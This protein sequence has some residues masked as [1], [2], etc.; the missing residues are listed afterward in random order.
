[1]SRLFLTFLLLLP[2]AAWAVA[3]T[4]TAVEGILHSA[5]GG[6]VADGE[7]TL[8]FALYP[9]S[10]N[11]AALWSEGPVAV[12]VKNG[13][14]YW[15]L[16]S[17]EPLKADVLALAPTI[18]LGIKV[19]ADPEMPRK[20]LLSV[21]FALQAATATNLACSGCVTVANL[22][23]A[24]LTPYAKTATLS[25]VA[26]SGEYGDLLNLP[27]LSAYAKNN[28]LADVAK[29]GKYADLQNAPDISLYAKTADLSVY[30]KLNLLAK[31]AS[32]GLYADL[33]DPPKLAPVATSG[34]YTDLLNAPKL[35]KV[36]TSGLFSDLSG[37]GLTLNVGLHPQVDPVG[38]Y[39][40][41]NT[42]TG[43]MEVFD[44]QKWWYFLSN[45]ASSDPNT[46][47]LLHFDGADGAKNST[48]ASS[49]K[50]V[51]TF[52]NNA[53]ISIGNSKFGGSSAYFDGA[54]HISIACASAFQ[55]AHGDMTVE[56]WFN[57]N[58]VNTSYQ[59]LYASGGDFHSPNIEYYEG[60]CGGNTTTF[61]WSTNNASWANGGLGTCG[62]SGLYQ[63][64]TWYHLALVRYAG[65]FYKYINGKLDGMSDATTSLQ[66][67]CDAP[68]TLGWWNKPGRY[69]SGYMD[70]VRV[71]RVAR[72]TNNFV[73]QAGAF[74]Q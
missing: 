30:A 62:A 6:A 57:L 63:S 74:L 40:L 70:E 31:V 7:Y 55:F 50:N 20:Q 71:S 72:Y 34:L 23:P 67:A 39:F 37:A 41:Y 4:V 5:G 27:D 38:T 54:S 1:M 35:A 46:V 66:A 3:P 58:D 52:A 10:S 36:A 11:G 9:S 16:G 26:T 22:D 19:G 13:G 32:S 53:K 56:F 12:N 24:I 68:I 33:L 60:G 17:T 48:D 73:P 29:T 18:W 21:P 51:L 28:T 25:K 2:A 15:A 69:L 61:F 42:A 47:L 14:F 8:N 49:Y 64:G 59:Y 44:G 65:R 43:N 45:A